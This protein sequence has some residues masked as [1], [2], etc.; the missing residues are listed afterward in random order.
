MKTILTSAAILLISANAAAN[1]LTK[2]FN[3]RGVGISEIY[4]SAEAIQK[5][6][7][8][9]KAKANSVCGHKARQETEFSCVQQP[10]YFLSIICEAYFSCDEN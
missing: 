7:F 8:Q 4:D 10:R 1:I 5:A 9:V 3:L 2:N 6:E